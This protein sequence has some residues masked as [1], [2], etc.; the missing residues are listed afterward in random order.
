[1]KH[2]LILGVVMVAGLAH[3]DLKCGGTEPFWNLTIG[4]HT[5]AYEDMEGKNVQFGTVT[6]QDA[7]GI[8]PGIVR[9]YDFK[10]AQST[11]DAVVL[12]QSCSDG[13][14]DV[15]YPYAI[16]LTIMKTVFSGCCR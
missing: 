6:V 15:T 16:T 5:A 13:M 12:K 8:K 4:S 2:I 9:K 11:A 14:S 3:A 1:M 7:R 10:N